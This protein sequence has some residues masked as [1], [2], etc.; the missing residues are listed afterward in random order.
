MLIATPAKINNTITV[1]TK[2]TSVIPFVF[3]KLAHKLSTQSFVE[4]T[5][6]NFFESSTKDYRLSPDE[7]SSFIEMLASSGD[8]DTNIT[9]S[10]TQSIASYQI[11]TLAEIQGFF[12]SRNINPLALPDKTPYTYTISIDESLHYQDDLSELT[13]YDI[14]EGLP[15]GKTA[16]AMYPTQVVYVDEPL[17][18]DLYAEIDGEIIEAVGD[19]WSS[20]TTGE[21][22]VTL[23]L[24]HVATEAQVN[25]TVLARSATCANGHT[26]ATTKTE[27]EYY[28]MYGH[29]AACAECEKEAESLTIYDYS[30][31]SSEVSASIRSLTLSA[32]YSEA[33]LPISIGV[34]YKDGHQAFYPLDKYSEFGILS[35]YDP[36][37]GYNNTPVTFVYQNCSVQLNVIRENGHCVKCGATITGRVHT[38]SLAYLYC[39]N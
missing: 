36:N 21:F 9:L 27:Y 11:H 17:L 15:A 22:T 30:D 24:D 32:D 31:P 20:S 8:F 28:K 18:T 33:Y 23:K 13:A 38:D 14:S 3:F 16:V 29:F 12:G 1:I 7:Y 26:F 10:K 39:D 37:Y 6:N 4:N 35:D 2:A 5:V 19:D 34:R 25:V